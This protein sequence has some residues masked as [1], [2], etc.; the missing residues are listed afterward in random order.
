ME[1]TDLSHSLWK[2]EKNCIIQC[3]GRERAYEL[4]FFFTALKIRVVLSTAYIRRYLFVAAPRQRLDNA[5]VGAFGLGLPLRLH[6]KNVRWKRMIR[7]YWE[8]K[9]EVSRIRSRFFVR[10][11]A[12]RGMLL[13]GSQQL[14]LVLL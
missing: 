13:C 8:I 1:L 7:Y 3:S 14:V 6:Y 4:L 2:T 5:A 11:R 9:T 12:L 10:R